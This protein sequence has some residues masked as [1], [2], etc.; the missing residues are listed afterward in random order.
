MNYK[1][2]SPDIVILDI[3]FSDSKISGYDILKA[4]KSKI[5][6]SKIIML[7]A[8]GEDDPPFAALQARLPIEALAKPRHLL[9][10]EPDQSRY[11]PC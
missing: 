8:F 7:T 11:A 4:I 1:F 10:G 5:P 6:K 9:T 2:Y 3:N